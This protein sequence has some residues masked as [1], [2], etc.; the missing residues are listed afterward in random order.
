[1][2]ILFFSSCYKPDGGPLAPLIGLLAESLAK[3]GHDVT[4]ISSVPHFPTG[5]VPASCKGWKVRR[6]V[7]NG[8]RII[9]IPLPSI[10]R[11]KLTYRMLQFLVYQVGAMLEGFFVKA[12][13]VISHTPGLEVWLP[14]TVHGLIRKRKT[15]YSIHDVYPDVGIRM[16]IFRS[17]CVISVVKAL[18]E[19]CIRNA[20]RVRVLSKSFIQ[21][22]HEM[23]AK[24]E[25]IILIYDW[26][27]ICESRLGTKKNAFAREY[28][29]NGAM[30]VFY[31]GN[32]GY[33]QGLDIVIEAAKILRENQNIRFVFVGDGGAKS[34]LE[35][36]A[37]I[38]RLDNILFI[39]YQPRERMSDVLACADIGLVSLKKGHG[40]GAL[41]SKIYTIMANGK[42]VIAS[43]DEGCDAWDLVRRADA[44]LCVPP[45]SPQELADAIVQ[46]TSS[47]AQP[48]VLG[49][50][51]RKYVVANHSPEHA[52]ELFERALREIVQ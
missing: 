9:R 28:G 45:E 16:G 49:E 44:G 51:G 17:R 38:Y 10:G 24:E 14:F 11:K 19:S 35:N 42:P 18:E 29:L 23:G 47:D 39:P 37:S 13:A 4:V 34:D 1:V 8:V 6:T 2:R 48:T 20:D 26:V 21:R 22:I 36:L 43:I 7:E 25:K 3:R 52:A 40:F 41:P 46:I 33:I 5:F 15:I 30:K 50:N 32:I 31:T 27:E 12:D